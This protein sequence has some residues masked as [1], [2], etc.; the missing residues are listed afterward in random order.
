M[1]FVL[2]VTLFVEAWVCLGKGTASQ[3]PANYHVIQ[4]FTLPSSSWICYHL[5]WLDFTAGF[6]G[7]QNWPVGLLAFCCPALTISLQSPGFKMLRVPR[8]KLGRLGLSLSRLHYKAVMALRR[9]DVNAWERRAPLAP[10]HI[11]GITNLGYKVLI[12][13]SNRRAIHDKVNISN[14]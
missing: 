3:W 14:F 13:P 5:S 2:E 10:R 11:K 8:T 12:Q 6:S 4:L 1:F 7:D 9:E